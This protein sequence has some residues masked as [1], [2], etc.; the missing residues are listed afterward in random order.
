MAV[1][2]QAAVRLFLQTI[3][4]MAAIVLASREIC[5]SPFL[6]CK[7]DASLTTVG[8]FRKLTWLNSKFMKKGKKN[9]LFLDWVSRSV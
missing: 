1:R 4:V 6:D 2:L 9:L 3:T 8:L 5:A 7:T